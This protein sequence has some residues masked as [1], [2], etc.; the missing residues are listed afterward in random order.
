MEYETSNILY[1]GG[2]SISNPSDS[3]DV[4]DDTN[5]IFR[6]KSGNTI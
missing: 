4:E 2:S 6:K 5:E 1:S 3:C